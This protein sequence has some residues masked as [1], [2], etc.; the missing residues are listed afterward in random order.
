MKGNDYIID[1]DAAR[2]P[3]NSYM[4]LP[5]DLLQQLTPLLMEEIMQGV[6]GSHGED[7]VVL[8][9][10]LDESKISQLNQVVSNLQKNLA[11]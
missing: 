7:H 6:V 8:H 11:V 5:L 10:V 2:R 9:L 4:V 1:I 3:F